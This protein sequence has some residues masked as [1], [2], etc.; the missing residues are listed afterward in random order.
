MEQEK[1]R[2]ELLDDLK[3]L[4]N[5]SFNEGLRALADVLKLTVRKGVNGPP[6]MIERICDELEK[7]VTELER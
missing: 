4:E 3:V 6:Q 2:R 5:M 7:A 1:M